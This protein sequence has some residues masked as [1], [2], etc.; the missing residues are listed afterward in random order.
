MDLVELRILAAVGILAVGVVASAL[1]VAAG[2]V[3][4]WLGRLRQAH[5]AGRD[6]AGAVGDASRLGAERA[7][8]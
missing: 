1:G 2:A 6:V 4:G 7:R 8:C 3:I 5:A